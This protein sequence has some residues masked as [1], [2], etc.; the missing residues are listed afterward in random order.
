MCRASVHMRTAV[1]LAP[2]STVRPLDMPTTTEDA[3]QDEGR[4]PRRSL[5]PV[6][7]RLRLVVALVSLLALGLAFFGY[8]TYTVYK[9]AQYDELDDQ[10]RAS[11]PILERILRTNGARPD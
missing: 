10:L 11:T 9:R 8:A 5:R 7:L 3:R 6:S 2:P 4:A 1:D